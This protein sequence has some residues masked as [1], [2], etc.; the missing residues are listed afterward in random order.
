M[1]PY[2]DLLK[3]E[4]MSFN[5]FKKIEIMSRISSSHNDMELE[6]E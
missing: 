1:G 5:K 2:K 4:A 3:V 6:I